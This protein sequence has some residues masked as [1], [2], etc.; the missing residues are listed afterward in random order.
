MTVTSHG[1]AALALPLGIPYLKMLRD[2]PRQGGNSELARLNVSAQPVFTRRSRCDV[3]DARDGD[4]AEHVTEIVSVKEKGEI[5][6]SRGTGESNTI[7]ASPGQHCAYAAPV[8]SVW[9]YRSIGGDDVAAGTRLLQCGWQVVTRHCGTRDKKIQTFKTLDIA[10]VSFERGEHSFCFELRGHDIDVDVGGSQSFRRSVADGTDAQLVKFI[11]LMSAR[12]HTAQEIV[13]AVDARENDPIVTVKM[14]NRFVQPLV[15]FGL[16]NLDRGAEQHPR[17]I[18]F[19]FR[20]ELGGLRT[21]T[22]DHDC[23]TGER[24]G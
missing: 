3:A 13:D 15:A 19:K 6:H 17:A 16:G 8:Q 5:P 21:C 12:F 9:L 20:N 18:L 1:K 7:R 4:T 2:S 14:S 10:D 11:G 24:P 23:A 22:R